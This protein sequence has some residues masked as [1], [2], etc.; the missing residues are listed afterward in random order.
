[1]R[2]IGLEPSYEL[3]QK[4]FLLSFLVEKGVDGI[5]IK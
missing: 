3:V 2:V 5:G 4:P 1:M